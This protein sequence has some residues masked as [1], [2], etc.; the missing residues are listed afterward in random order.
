MELNKIHINTLEACRYC[1][2][3]RHVCSSELISYKESDSPRGRAILLFNILY[4]KDE[5]EKSVVDSIFNCFL[6]GCCWSWCVGRDEG[7]YNIPELIRFAR[8]DIIKRGFVPEMAKKIKDSILENNNQFN[9][10]KDEGYSNKDNTSNTNILYYMDSEIGFKNFEIADSV[11]NILNKLKVDFTMLKD[12]YSGSKLLDILGFE[13]EYIERIKKIYE[14]I[15]ATG[16]K[17]ILLSDPL[18]YEMFKKD[19]AK[20]GLNLEPYIKVMHIS[21]FLSLKL[22]DNSI[23]LNKI[24]K[25]VTLIDSEYLGRF[26]NIYDEP[27]SIVK[28]S[29]G[30]NFVELRWSREK[31]KSAGEAALLFNS[32]RF[33]LGV[34]LAEQFINLAKEIDAKLIITLSPTTKNMI[35]QFPYKQNMEVL[36]IAEFVEKLL[37]LT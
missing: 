18:S 14:Q 27:R 25:K 5:Y 33:E 8:R 3:C 21:E 19:F 26:N 24:N 36:D 7:G 32:K 35:K 11:L 28:S 34:N 17:T 20:Y 16:C 31:M 1:P 9:I 37:L 12:E 6:C 30:E 29:A 4:S 22:K 23:K 2:M 13:D 15:K 10:S